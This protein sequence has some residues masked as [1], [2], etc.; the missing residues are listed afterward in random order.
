MKSRQMFQIS[1]NNCIVHFLLFPVI[2]FSQMSKLFIRFTMYIIILMKYR[3]RRRMSLMAS[4]RRLYPLLKI[5]LWICLGW[6]FHSIGV[7]FQ[8]KEPHLS[9]ILKIVCCLPRCMP[10]QTMVWTRWMKMR[11]MRSCSSCCPMLQCSAGTRGGGIPPL[12]CSVLPTTTSP[13]QT[14]KR[15][16][17]SSLSHTVTVRECRSSPFCCHLKR[18]ELYE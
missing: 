12:P 6:M 7:N 14:C 1:Q 10:H 8:A 11:C 4:V 2:C 15:W 3:L 13:P 16:L 9:V 17:E 5:T 18:A